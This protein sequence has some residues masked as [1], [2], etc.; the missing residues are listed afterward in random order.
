MYQVF[1][2]ADYYG[3]SVAMRV[4]PFR[5][6]RIYAYPTCSVF[7]SPVRFLASVIS[8]YS[9]PR[10]FYVATLVRISVVSP[11]FRYVP[12]GDPITP[13]ETRIEPIQA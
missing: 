9:P 7:R 3:G 10:A 2:G 11:F 5:R 6:S 13:L 12:A 8:D 4:S 1:P